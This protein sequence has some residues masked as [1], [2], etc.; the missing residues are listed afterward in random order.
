MTTD[1]TWALYVQYIQ[2]STQ[3]TGVF[4]RNHDMHMRPTDTL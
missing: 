2:L 4:N 3:T 1:L